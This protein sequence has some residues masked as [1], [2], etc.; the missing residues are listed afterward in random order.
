MR[1]LTKVCGRATEE[2]M[3]EMKRIIKF[4]LDTK[5]IGL[6]FEPNNNNETMEMWELIAY[7]D[8]DW[9]GDKDNRKSVSGWIIYLLG[10]PISHKS[11]QQGTV[12]LSSAEAEWIALSEAIKELL[13]II[14]VLEEI[15]VNVIKPV[16]VMVDNQAAI[17]MA[18]NTTATKRTKH[19]DVRANFVYEHVNEDTGE[20]ELV[21]VKSEENRSDVF[22]KNVSG[23]VMEDH[24]EYLGKE[25]DLD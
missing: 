8:S 7:S 6:K 13:F 10:C 21:F 25:E 15:G 20:I 5:G 1:E 24:T 11:R 22:T 12:S 3:M 16:K 23:E 4:V 2:A 9:A 18:K 19:V 14:Q 17:F